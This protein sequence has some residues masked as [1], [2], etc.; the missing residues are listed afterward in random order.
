MKNELLDKKITQLQ[1]LSDYY[2]D[3]HQ[4]ISCIKDH[5]L[6]YWLNDPLPP[7]ATQLSKLSRNASGCLGSSRKSSRHGI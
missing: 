7:K 4:R 3:L 6:D 2:Q 5:P 1:E